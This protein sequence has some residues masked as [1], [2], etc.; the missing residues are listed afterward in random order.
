MA[1]FKRKHLDEG[2]KGGS[3]NFR[4]GELTVV[5]VGIQC[6]AGTFQNASEDACGAKDEGPEASLR[7]ST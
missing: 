1:F 5:S 3:H 2:E 6:T 7:S 4:R